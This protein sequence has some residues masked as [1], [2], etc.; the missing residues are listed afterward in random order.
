MAIGCIVENGFVGSFDGFY[1]ISTGCTAFASPRICLSKLPYACCK[2]VQYVAKLLSIVWN[3][4][5]PLKQLCRFKQSALGQITDNVLRQMGAT[6]IIDGVQALMQ[7]M[8]IKT[9]VV[10]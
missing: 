7:N 10:M 4:A 3:C 2:C 6:R 9:R 8:D 1:I 5:R